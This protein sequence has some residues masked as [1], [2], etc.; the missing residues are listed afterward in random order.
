L[1]GQNRNNGDN[2]PSNRSDNDD[3]DRLKK[4]LVAN[5]VEDKSSHDNYYMSLETELD[6]KIP[7]RDYAELAIST[8]KRTVKQE[9][10]LVRQILYTGISKDSTNAIIQ[11]NYP[12]Q[13][14]WI[15]FY[16]IRRF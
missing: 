10:S 11:F 15:I 1:N 14:D 4:E 6:S 16:N 5:Q 9:D 8:I 3:I 12:I 13:I 2:A 7:D